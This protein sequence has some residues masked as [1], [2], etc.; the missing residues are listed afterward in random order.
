MGQRHVRRTRSPV[1]PRA[2]HATRSGGP[3]VRRSAI[4]AAPAVPGAT[5]D[6]S[7]S[8]DGVALIHFASP[9]LVGTGSAEWPEWQPT[10]WVPDPIRAKLNPG[11]CAGPLAE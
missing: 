11:T 5:L 9:A 8:A 1:R 7:I 10:H 2:T 4:A 6:A 3:T